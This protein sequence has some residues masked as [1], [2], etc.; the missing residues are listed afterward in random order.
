MSFP[1]LCSESQVSSC[2][3]LLT[4]LEIGQT[5]FRLDGHDRIRSLAFASLL[6]RR[7]SSFDARISVG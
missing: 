1:Q 7:L 3:G 2:S 6:S 5:R 4:R